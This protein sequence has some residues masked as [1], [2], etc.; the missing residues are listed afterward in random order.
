MKKQFKSL[1]CVAFISLLA[2]PVAQANFFLWELNFGS[3]DFEPEQG[4][5]ESVSTINLAYGGFLTQFV[6]Y[7]LQYGMGWKDSTYLTQT[8][9]NTH[10]AGLV[11]FNIGSRDAYVSLMSGVGIFSVDTATNTSDGTGAAI[12]ISMNMYATP[13]SGLSFEILN[14]TD[15]DEGQYGQISL[16]FKRKF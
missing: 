9:D 4:S 5:A 8:P 10:A 1:V 14:I 13:Q 3:G 12:A 2:M 16:G 11:G 7:E 15:S 6:T